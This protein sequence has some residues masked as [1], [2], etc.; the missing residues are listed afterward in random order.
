MHVC[1]IGAG[2]AGMSAALY[3]CSEGA[4]VTVVERFSEKGYDRYHSICGAG[5]SRKA[6]SELKYI[7]P[8]CVRNE[9]GRAVLHFPDGID[10]P[11]T[12]KGYVLDR[13]AFI[14][15]YLS[16]CR[17]RGCTFVHGEAE[18]VIDSGSGCTVSL[19]DGTEVR[20]DRVI[21][22][23]GSS[24][25]IRKRVFGT[26]PRYIGSAEEFVTEGPSEP[27]FHMYLEGRFNGAYRWEFPSG[28]NR[29]VGSVAGKYAPDSYMSRGIRNIPTGGVPEIEKGNVF[30]A[31]DSAAMANPICYGGLR[32]ALLAGQEAA[33]AALSGKHGRYAR[34]WNRSMMS[35]KRFSMMK[36][37]IDQW[38]DEDYARVA[39]PLR[40]VTRLWLTGIKASILHP[41]YVHLYIGC[42]MTFRYGW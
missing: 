19:K 28:G 37:E 3:L 10:V 33:K 41:R 31:G 11:M 12:V 38:T 7:E 42:L 25:L 21:A 29:N 9:I 40:H 22:C 16:I 1:V 15:H 14:R 20:C 35:N 17:D 34:W 36:E 24:S 13:P 8:V 5:I 2:P 4:Q 23:D 27:V 26:S 6:F 30:L 32:A 39:E 18:N